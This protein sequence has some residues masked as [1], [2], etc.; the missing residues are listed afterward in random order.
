VNFSDLKEIAKAFLGPW[1]YPLRDY[2]FGPIWEIISG[3]WGDPLNYFFWV[4]V[5][6]SL[7]IALLIFLSQRGMRGRISLKEFF[8]FCAPKEI[9]THKSAIVDYKYYVVNAVVYRVLFTGGVI[10]YVMLLP[11]YF[12]LLL[13][14]LF[15]AEGP[16][17]EAGIT[18][19]IIFTVLAVVMLDLGST[20][21]HYFQHKVAF[22]WEFHKIHHSA[23][24]L[25]PLTRYRLHPFDLVLESLSVSIF[26]NALTGTFSYLYPKE[27]MEFMVMNISVIFFVYLLIANLRHS[28][29]W[30]SYGWRLSHVISSPAMHQIHHSSDEK[31]FDKNYAFVL[32]VWDWLLGTLY[33]PREKEKLNW[34]LTDWERKSYNSVWNLYALP[35]KNNFALLRGRADMDFS[36]GKDDF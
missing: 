32:S 9:Y 18:S 20:L 11:G 13:Q 7:L 23:E 12:R 14:S 8:R 1:Y 10:G 34:G 15:G 21:C 35:F 28:H 4:Y 16:R 33:V 19:R 24:V 3:T 31:H 30:L 29:I 2:L 5:M 17:W 6:S 26:T 27:V 36:E 25:T 22:L